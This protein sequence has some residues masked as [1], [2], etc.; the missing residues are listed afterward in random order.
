[1]LLLKIELAGRSAMSVSVGKTREAEKAEPG[2]RGRSAVGA[3]A[4]ATLGPLVF[5]MS[6]GFSSPAT[7]SMIRGPGDLA[8]LEDKDSDVFG[9]AIN[10]GCVVGALV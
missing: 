3:A 1:M 4:V 9:A 8:V 2:S 5:G 10:L 6:L 7:S